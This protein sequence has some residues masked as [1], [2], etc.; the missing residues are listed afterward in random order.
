MKGAIPA[1][2]FEAAQYAKASG[3]PL[4]NDMVYSRGASALGAAVAIGEVDASAVT[5]DA[6]NHDFSLYSGVASVSAKPGLVRTEIMVLGNSHYWSGELRIEHS[7]M[8][9]ILDVDAVVDTL[10]RLGMT[11]PGRQPAPE[12]RDRVVAV[13]AKSEADPRSH[14]R[15]QRHV[16]LSD[17]DVSDT[18]WSRCTLAAVLASVVGDGRVY[19]STRAEHMGPL[20]GGPVAIIAQV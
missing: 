10:S 19:V 11:F 14:V 15:G 5:D 2:T 6:I 13:M 18:R 20:G 17:D 7:V 1:S 8:H 16:M 9:D 12:Q 3:K 4:R